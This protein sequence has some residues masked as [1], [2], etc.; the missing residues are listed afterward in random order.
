MTRDA[1]VDAGWFVDLAAAVLPH[2]TDVAIFSDVLGY[3]RD[4][5]VDRYPRCAIMTTAPRTRISS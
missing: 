2:E 5:A 3:A 1:E 4:F